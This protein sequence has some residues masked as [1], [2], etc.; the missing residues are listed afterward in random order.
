[1]VSAVVA[2][3]DHGFAPNTPVQDHDFPPDSPAQSGVPLL[4]DHGQYLLAGEHGLRIFAAPA[5]GRA[6]DWVGAPWLVPPDG[7]YPL[8]LPNEHPPYPGDPLFSKR[9]RRPWFW[10]DPV[11]I[12]PQPQIDI[13]FTSGDRGT[14]DG[15]RLVIFDSLS[16]LTINW[17]VYV[18]EQ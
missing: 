9:F 3:A 6:P 15:H 8:R 1:M 16:P 12:A 10:E 17:K 11:T 7:E 5:V 4:P 2:I 14:Y 18:E 13:R